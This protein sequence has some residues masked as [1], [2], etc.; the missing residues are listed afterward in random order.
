MTEKGFSSSVAFFTLQTANIVLYLELNNNIFYMTKKILGP[1]LF[2]IMITLFWSSCTSDTLVPEVLPNTPVSFTG[3][4]QP[5]FDASCSKSGCHA[6]GMV[7]PDLTAGKSYSS[8]MSMNLIDTVSPQQST[9]Y[10]EVKPGGGM[11]SYCTQTQSQLIL[12]WIEQGA[13]NN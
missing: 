12:K 11:S 10:Q 1:A 7:A 9:L 2:I 8:L 3:Q 6:T 5:I 4:I 13:K